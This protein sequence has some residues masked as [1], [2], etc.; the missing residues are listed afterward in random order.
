MNA[1]EKEHLLHLFEIGHSL[2][3]VASQFGFLPEE[4]QETIVGMGW[5]REVALA[6]NSALFLR[7]SLL[8]SSKATGR[9]LASEL[10]TIHPEIWGRGSSTAQK[11][12]LIEIGGDELAELGLTGSA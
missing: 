9:G 6:K 12:P 1:A 7:E 3:A 4:L 2:P 8:F 5:Q 10:A 11:G